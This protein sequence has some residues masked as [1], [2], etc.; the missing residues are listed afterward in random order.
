[1]ARTRN[2]FR[3]IAHAWRALPTWVEM[4][5]LGIVAVTLIV[6][7]SA[8]VWATFAPIPAINNFESRQ[9]AQST[10]IYDR[11]GNIVLYDVHGAMRRTSVPIEAISPYIKNAAV[12]V[13]DSTFYENAGFRPLSFLRAV[14]ANVFSG[15]YVQGGSTITQQVVKNALLTRDKTITRKIKEIILAL[16]LTRVYTKDQI[17]NTYLNETSYG[18][19]IYGVEEASQYFFGVSAK[20][21][22]LAQAAYLAALPQAPTY[23]S[24]HGNHKEALDAR[25]NFVLR[26]MKENGLIT[27]EEYEQALG[28]QVEFKDPKNAGIKAPHFVFYIQ[29][30]LE[31]KYGADAV[32]QEGLRVITTLDYDLQQQ[33]EES[34]AEFA[35]GLLSRLNASNQGMVAVDPKT[36]QVLAMVGSKG[37]FDDTIDGK[38][39]VTI[40]KRQ[41]GSAF[42]PFVYATAFAKGYTPNTMVFDLPTQFSTRCSPADVSNTTYPCYA[43]TNFDGGFEGPMTLRAALA[44]SENIPAIKVLYLAG[45]P[46]SIETAENLGI[47]TLGSPGRHG[48]ALVLGGGE[49][50]LLEMTGAYSVFANDGIKNPVTGVLRVEDNT[51]AILESFEPQSVQV[52]DSQVARTLN[53][54]LSDNVARSPEF[55]LNSPLF[56]RGYDVAAK[57]GTTNDFRDAWVIGYTPGIAVGAWTGNNDNKSMVQNAA[58]FLVAPM[59]H[60]FMIYA[61]S[62]YSSASDTFPAPAP[63]ADVASLPPVLSGNWNTDPSQGVH[64]ILYWINKDDP[65]NENKPRSSNDVQFPYWD[66][67]VAAWAGQQIASST[68]TTAPQAGPAMH[69]RIASPGAGSTIPFGSQVTFGAESPGPQTVLSVSYF[70]NGSLV[71]TS[72]QPPYIVMY[73]PGAPGPVTLRAVASRTDGT[74][75]EETITFSVQ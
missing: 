12:A 43:P 70:A 44:R 72:G 46:Q 66:Y 21:V 34:V 45:I 48:L 42:K 47:T 5:I 75:E 8:V 55:G 35:P 18:G 30:Y 57:T 24:P 20:D 10:K 65:R 19:T 51:G 2:F 69:F 3:R 31:R 1:M 38:V 32:S 52:L 67:S 59:W 4:G 49:V 64:D 28:E 25:K 15:S 9:V 53:D 41:P 50:T 26:Q 11:T 6:L 56:F 22:D 74:S 14:A 60:D 36:G 7:G 63:D 33:A 13:E 23:Y 40:A 54:I 16:R 73:I 68:D 39:N 27:N 29:E 62:K 37:Y 58:S 61:L 17:L 71:G